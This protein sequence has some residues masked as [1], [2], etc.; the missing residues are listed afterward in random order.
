MPDHDPLNALKQDPQA[1]ALL[2]DPKA[3][4][5]LLGSKEAQT[6]ARLHQQAGATQL[7]TA[8]QAAVSGHPEALDHILKNVSKTADGKAAME[9]L[10]Q[11]GRG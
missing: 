4:S 5:A 1:A 11:R 10:E 9:A 7:Q 8:A 6:D 2:S 3:L